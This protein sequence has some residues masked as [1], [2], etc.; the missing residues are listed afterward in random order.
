MKRV[1]VVVAALLVCGASVALA[2][3]NVGP[4]FTFGASVSYGFDFNDPN[5][6][7]AGTN[8]LSYA[9]LEPQDEAF[10]IDLV[11][12]GVRGARG[13]AMYGAKI[14]FGDLARLAGDAADGD[15]GLQEAFL[16]YNF[17][18]VTA[19]AGRFPTPIGY[20][21]LEPWNNAQISRSRAWV[22]FVPISHDGLS[23]SSEFENVDLM[24]AVINSTFVNDPVANDSNDDKGVVGSIG[25]DI[26]EAA[27]SVAGLFS[28]EDLSAG[29]GKDD[30]SM[31]NVIV[32]GPI[33]RFNFALEGNWARDNV[34][35]EIAI[36]RPIA[37]SPTLDFW[38]I[39]LYAGTDLGE[40][41]G[42]DLRADYGQAD[43]PGIGDEVGVWSITN[44]L[45]YT[46]TDGMDIRVE[47]R[48]DDFEED[49]FGDDNDAFSKGS[50]HTLQAQ[51]V[52]TPT[53]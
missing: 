3:D 51:V 33:S 21:V 46:L 10:N 15:V 9:N 8:A 53:L 4:E 49:F 47:H 30:Q 19:T 34:H 48:Y 40:R 27:I 36:P 22:Q 12:L 13:S 45:S 11:Q 25:F 18:M 2:E 28:P 14:D 7:V 32:S 29:F 26:G 24:F 37:T 38:N 20:E 35:G 50:M 41:F 31:V 52:W 39:V 5:V 17:G 23:I 43:I 44:T 6:D 16:G 1:L 42:V